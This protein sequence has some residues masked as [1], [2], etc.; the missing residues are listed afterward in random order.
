MKYINKKNIRT[1]FPVIKFLG[2]FIG[3]IFLYYLMIM[4]TE[5]SIFNGYIQFITYLSGNV[6]NI[7]SDN[8][9]IGSLWLRYN[10]FTISVAF[11]CEGTEPLIIFLAGVFAFPIAFKYKLIGASLGI[12]VLLV[13]NIFRI[14]AL[15]LIGFHYNE[16]FTSFHEEI[17]PILF[18]FI[19]ILLWLI[20]I[21]SSLK[22]SK[23]P[24][25]I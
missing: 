1:Y 11:G 18:I 7:F 25:K 8:V 15:V 3:I 23:V 12:S 14:V 17:F 2:I 22:H 20:W 5:N 10:T 13:L 9:E 6:L 4:L 19:S 16:M 24:S 21:Q